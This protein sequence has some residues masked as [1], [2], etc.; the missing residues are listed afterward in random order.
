MS[1]VELKFTPDPVT[2]TEN[3]LLGGDYYPRIEP[4]GPLVD[5]EV[6]RFIETAS[7]ATINLEAPI[8][9]PASPATKHGPTLDLQAK[10]INKLPTTGIDGVQL[11]NNHIM[12]Y[13]KKGLRQ[14]INRCE[15]R[16]LEWMG[17]G[18]SRKEALE[19]TSFDIGSNRISIINA[20]DREFGTADDET[21]GYAW[22]GDSLLLQTIEATKKRSDIVVLVLHG[23][24]EYEPI[25]AVQRQECYRKF[26][27]NG[28]DAII[29]HHPHVPKGWEVHQG[30]PI[31]YS[32]GH[33]LFDFKPEYRKPLTEWGLLA[34]LRI[35]KGSIE[36][37]V[38]IPIT[39]H[40][41][42]PRIRLHSAHDER[43]LYLEQCRKIV[44]ESTVF[45]SLWQE[46]AVSRY[47]EYYSNRFNQSSL[48]RLIQDNH[49]QYRWLQNVSQCEAHHW[50]IRTATAVLG[51]TVQDKRSDETTELLDSLREQTREETLDRLRRR[52]GVPIRDHLPFAK[53]R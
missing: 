6:K 11:A 14:T 46:L 9:S 21:P 37:I 35:E 44:Q 24:I 49:A 32:L 28:A 16:D 15:S 18:S 40:Y 31:C 42:S 17:A 50:C 34:D 48:A 2:E 7:L 19:P 33:F 45:S 39:Q 23:G 29:G 27:E 12:D 51:G 38:L 20:G 13:G 43:E 1:K 5:E 52:I 30:T 47:N 41:E 8:H 53:T 4:D 10:F 22:V 36:K 26:A 3:V 25:P